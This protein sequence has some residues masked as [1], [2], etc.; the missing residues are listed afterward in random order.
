M[1]PTEPRV[2][3]PVDLTLTQMKISK[4]NVE[5]GNQAMASALLLYYHLLIEGGITHDQTVYINPDH[6]DGFSFLTVCVEENLEIDETFLREAS[7][8]RLLCD[9]NDMIDEYEND[10]WMQPISK[11]IVNA[12]KKGSFSSIPET[13]ELF[14]EILKKESFDYKRYRLILD[15]IFRDYVMGRFKMLTNSSSEP[16]ASVRTG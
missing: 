4:A 13:K 14:S 16:R 5:I 2:H 8:I 7:V 3:G 9:L 15:K 6:F 10:F 12:Y 11:Q 1:H